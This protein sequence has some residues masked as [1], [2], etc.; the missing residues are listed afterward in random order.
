MWTGISGLG[1][2]KDGRTHTTWGLPI[3]QAKVSSLDCLP[4]FAAHS[5]PDAAVPEP[6]SGAT[7]V[8]GMCEPAGSKLIRDTEVL[9][10]LMTTPNTESRKFPEQF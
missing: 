1:S 10:S 2:G 8:M 6:G 7:Y 3:A 9:E 4:C 5:L